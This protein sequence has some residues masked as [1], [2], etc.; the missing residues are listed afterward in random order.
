MVP[1][2]LDILQALHP[3][4][5]LSGKG[6]EGGV[7]DNAA[8][9]V[10]RM[11]MAAPAAVPMDQVMYVFERFGGPCSLVEGVVSRISMTVVAVVPVVAKFQGSRPFRRNPAALYGK[12]LFSI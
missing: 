2:Y 11:I 3:L 9:A 6:V 7:V 8:A 12:S 4:F 5:Q 1:H 10:A